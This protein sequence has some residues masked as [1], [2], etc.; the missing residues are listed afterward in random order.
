[1]LTVSELLS[2]AKAKQSIASNYRLA[3]LLGVP[4]RSVQ[5]WHAGDSLPSDHYCHQLAK[6]AGLDVGVVIASVHAQR[7]GTD[8]ELG[9]LW[10]ELA[11]RLQKTAV[12]AC[13]AL[14]VLLGGG[15]DGDGAARVDQGVS[16]A[17]MNASGV[18]PLYIMSTHTLHLASQA[19]ARF[20][21]FF[22][23]LLGLRFAQA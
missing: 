7:E 10:L 4:D 3:R 1:M 2:A 16:A 22:S 13:V 9:R 8:S 18:R 14:A 19:L 5:R 11:D 21:A 12:S 23:G 17:A 20:C 15:G 6:M